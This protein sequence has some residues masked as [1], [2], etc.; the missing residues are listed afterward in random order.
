MV[1]ARVLVEVP[2][3]AGELDAGQSIA[4][5]IENGSIRRKG[6][7]P[8]HQS[9]GRRGRCLAQAASSSAVFAALL[10]VPAGRDP[11]QAI[12]VADRISNPSHRVRA[13]VEAAPHTRSRFVAEAMD[14]GSGRCPR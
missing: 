10:R 14:P 1:T 13:L 8:S 11:G 7:D 9:G 2:A 6:A 4:G 3:T 12:S 5:I